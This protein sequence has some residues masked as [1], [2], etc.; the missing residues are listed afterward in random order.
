MVLIYCFLVGG[1]NLG[2]CV[3]IHAVRNI[4]TYSCHIIM[5]QLKGISSKVV[6]L[7]VS[8]LRFAQARF[9]LVFHG[10]EPVPLATEHNG[11][12]AFMLLM[13]GHLSGIFV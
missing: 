6:F 2:T 1:F 9:K 13:A 11:L 5:N 10:H 4:H 3:Q 7:L 8:P 12:L